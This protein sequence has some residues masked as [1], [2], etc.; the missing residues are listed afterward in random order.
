[1]AGATELDSPEARQLPFLM[2][3]LERP[4]LCHILM[5]ALE[6]AVKGT[7]GWKEWEP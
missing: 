3:A 4:E 6:E 7:D 2:A 5:N 1:M